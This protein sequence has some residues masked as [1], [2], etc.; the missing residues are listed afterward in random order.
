MLKNVMENLLLS[1][2]CEYKIERSAEPYLHS[3]VSADIISKD[4][5]KI[6]WFGK[7]H[8]KVLKNYD[9]NHDVYYAELDT[10]YLASLPEKKFAVKELSKFPAVERDIAVVVDEEVTNKELTSAIKSACGKYFD[11]V[12]LF[13]VYRSEQLGENKKSLA[14]KIRLISEE[15]TLTTEEINTIINKV[16]RSLEFRYRAKLRV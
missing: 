12:E 9:I 15:K 1:T 4:G 6:G 2:S 3:G 11:G 16:L 14:Y 5:K 8:K 7:I 10:D 13:D